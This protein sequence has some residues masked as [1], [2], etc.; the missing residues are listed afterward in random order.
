MKTTNNAALGSRKPITRRAARAI[1][2]D[3]VR[4]TSATKFLVATL[5]CYDESDVGRAIRVLGV[6]EA[7]IAAGLAA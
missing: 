6:D 7:L 3:F 4:A 1:V 5:A 2:A